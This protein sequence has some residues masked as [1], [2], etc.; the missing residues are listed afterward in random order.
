MSGG[1]EDR[2]VQKTRGLL[3]EALVSLIIEKGFE[4]V[5]IQE[6]I[7]KANVGRSTFYI[8]FENKQALL[9][10]CF[11]EFHGLFEK[12]GIAAADTESF[13]NN[14]FSLSLFRL[15]E[16][17]KR[18]CRALLGRDETVF[19]S[20]IH[21]FIFDY[22]GGSVKKLFPGKTQAPPRSEMLPHYITGALLGTLQWW[23]S[24]DMPYTAEEMD[25][26]FKKLALRGIQ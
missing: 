6:I 23:V 1:A 19:F 2:R 20:P 4:E 26:A 18:L 22:L 8:H 17:N 15:V 7:D 16:K 9:H 24:N 25:A 10:S 14:G 21:R 13:L 11:E 12:Y 5:T 3:K